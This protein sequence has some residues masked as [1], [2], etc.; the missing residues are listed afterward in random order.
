MVHRLYPVKIR[1]RRTDGKMQRKIQT[2]PQSESEREL[3]LEMKVPQ[4]A[5]V[6]TEGCIVLY[7]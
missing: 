4:K 7:S 1:E 2:K 3:N 6:N 5:M